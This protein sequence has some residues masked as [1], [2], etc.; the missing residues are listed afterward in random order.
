MP[1]ADGIPDCASL[2]AL[3]QRQGFTV[4]DCP[5]TP[6]VTLKLSNVVYGKTNGDV[7]TVQAKL[8]NLGFNPGPQDGMYGDQTRAAYMAFEQTLGGAVTPD[9][10]AGCYS[11][12]ELGS[13]NAAPV[14]AVSCDI[15]DPAPPTTNPPPANDGEPV[16]NYTRG[17]FGFGGGKTINKRTAD[18]LNL[19]VVQLSDSYDW[20]P[21]LVQGSY[22]PGVDASAGTHDGGGVIDIRVTTM[23]ENGRN[24]CVQALRQVGFA[25]WYR[26]P[27]EGFDVHIHACAIGDREMAPSAKNQVQSYF[28]GRNGLANN[29][30]DSLPSSYRTP[31]P[32][33]PAWCNKYDL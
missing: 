17:T 29:G 21:Y 31:V 28:N 4:S 1:T 23:S 18:M 24:L 9:G 6:T 12:G 11:L 15:A 26:T 16:H 30:P 27:A 22:N 19:A 3:G 2:V 7:Q 33:W 13:R 14:F 32:M 20:S 5:V 8:T 10:I 25:A